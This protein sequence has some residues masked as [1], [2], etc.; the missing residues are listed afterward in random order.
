MIRLSKIVLL[1]LTFFFLGCD[2]R[3]LWTDGA[4]KVL[5]ID[6]PENPKLCYDLGERGFKGGFICRVEAVVEVGS[7]ERFIATKSCPDS[8]CSYYYLEKSLDDGFIDKKELVKGPYSAKEYE[9][10]RT[11]SGLPKTKELIR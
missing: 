9:A 6:T 5:L 3:I 1:S 4:H 2:Y 7:N 10:K 11:I 8:G